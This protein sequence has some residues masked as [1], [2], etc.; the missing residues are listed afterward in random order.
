MV[1]LNINESDI[2]F[3]YGNFKFY[4]S[5]EFNKRRFVERV[6]NYIDSENLK[7]QIKYDTNLNFE[8]ML[9]FSF[10]KKIE[11]RGFK[12]IE[13]SSEKQIPESYGIVCNLVF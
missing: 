3:D 6:L 10:Y 9:L 5:S 12:V 1:Y 7:L 11:K 13:I 8:K 4:F 2:N